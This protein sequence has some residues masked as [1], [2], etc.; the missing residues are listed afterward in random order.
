MGVE[1]S[2]LEAAFEKLRAEHEAEHERRRA[3]FAKALADKLGIS[4]EKVEQELEEAP[5]GGRGRGR[6]PG[7]F[8]RHGGPR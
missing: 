6:G 1:E 3:A 2:K 4:A 7:G 8:G 5:F